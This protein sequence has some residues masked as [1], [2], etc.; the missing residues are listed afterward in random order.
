M[1]IWGNL[2]HQISQ[3]TSKQVFFSIKSCAKLNRQQI[4]Q[5]G[6]HHAFWGCFLEVDNS[7][8]QHTVTVFKTLENN[9]FGYIV[10]EY[11]KRSGEQPPTPKKMF[12]NHLGVKNLIFLNP[13]F[14]SK[15]NFESK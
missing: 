3:T 14:A 15:R 4:W 8:R 1:V 13:I 9:A 5:N 10:L 7:N 11:V 2:F 6:P 12:R